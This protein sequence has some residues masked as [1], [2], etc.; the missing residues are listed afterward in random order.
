MRVG[1]GVSQDL[2]EGP[3]PWIP[4]GQLWGGRPET[5]QAEV[6][7]PV[8][9]PTCGILDMPLQY[10]PPRPQALACMLRG[11]WRSS[12]DPGEAGPQIPRAHLGLFWATCCFQKLCFQKWASKNGNVLCGARR[13]GHADIHTHI[14]K[15]KYGKTE[16]SFNHPH[17]HKVKSL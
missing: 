16:K 17:D 3:W 6:R 14:W 12:M 4:V 11:S 5:S 7:L 2:K 13:V 9:T 8:L 1:P 15:V 10:V